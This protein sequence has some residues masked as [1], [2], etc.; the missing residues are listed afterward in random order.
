MDVM[1]REAYDARVRQ[2]QEL[3]AARGMVF[4]DWLNSDDAAGADYHNWAYE[5]ADAGT[6]E[7]LINF[8]PE[9]GLDEAEAFLRSGMTPA[10]WELIRHTPPPGVDS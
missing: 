4:I 8:H 3:A 5:L 9:G 2:L 6:G 10:A 1:T 7:C